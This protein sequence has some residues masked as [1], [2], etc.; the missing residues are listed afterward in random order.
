MT[1]M[2]FPRSNETDDSECSNVIVDEIK[3]QAI[4]YRKSPLTKF[5]A[6]VNEA[7]IYPN[8]TF[9]NRGELLEKSRKLVADEG[10]NFKKGTSRSKVYGDVPI[11]SSVQS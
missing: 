5:Q 4:I 10:Y 11:H 9:G 6:K 8:Q 1:Q 3:R 7:A 2:I